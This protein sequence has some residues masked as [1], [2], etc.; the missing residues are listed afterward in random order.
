MRPAQALETTYLQELVRF[1]VGG[2]CEERS[3]S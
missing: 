1:T 3:V 2:L